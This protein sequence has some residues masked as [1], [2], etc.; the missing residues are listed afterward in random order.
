[1]LIALVDLLADGLIVAKA[2]KLCRP[3]AMFTVWV[4]FC[5]LL[6]S[7]MCSRK[8]QRNDLGNEGDRNLA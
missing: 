7:L 3:P 1:L 4:D 2:R 8:T 5:W 6:Q